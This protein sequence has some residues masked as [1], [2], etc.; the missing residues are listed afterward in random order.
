MKQEASS[1]EGHW[2]EYYARR[3]LVQQGLIWLASNYRSRVG[4]IDLVMQTQAGVLVFVEV[5]QRTS[6]MFGGAVQSVTR[7][8]QEKLLR[9]AS[10]YLMSHPNEGHQGI[11]FDVLA[12]D[13]HPPSVTWIKQ[14]FEE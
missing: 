12:L 5:R 14:A 6:N 9:T 8:K 3:Y 2:A 7:S 1:S 4:E 13:G 10:H 11:R